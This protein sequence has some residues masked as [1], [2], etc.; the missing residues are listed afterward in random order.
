MF[1]GIIAVIIASIVKM[2]MKN[3]PLRELEWAIV[4]VVP[5]GILGGTIFGKAFIPGMI[6]YHVFFFWEPGM[7]LFGALALGTAAG[8]VWFYKRSK[9]T[10]I[11]VW[12][13]ADCILP[14]V[15]LG[16]AIGRWGN[17]Y[18]HEIMGH[19]VSYQSLGWMADSIRNRLFYFPP[20]LAQ[21]NV[22]S[23]M[24][25]NIQNLAKN[26]PI[27]ASTD[28][29]INAINM[30]S[31]IKV[32]NVEALATALASPIQ[33]REPLFLYE[34]MANCF[35]WFIL[36]FIVANLSRWIQGK[37]KYP[38]DINPSAYP[39]W[40]NNKYK[41]LPESQVSMTTAQ[42]PIKYKKVMIKNANGEEREIK[43]SFYMAWNKAYY[44][45]EA[46]EHQVD[47][48]MEKQEKNIEREREIYEKLDFMKTQEKNSKKRIKTKYQ[49]KFNNL[50]K[51][52]DK[53]A[54][55]KKDYDNELVL[56]TKNYKEQ[57]KELH[58]ELGGFWR[59]F[60]PNPDAR[61]LEEINN[62]N[63]YWILRCGVL[64]GGYVFG[65]MLIR[66]ILET[67]R[68]PEELFVQNYPIAD[69]IVLAIILLMGI[70]IIGIAQF[71][72]PYKWR[73]VGWLYEK[74]Y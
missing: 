12:V 43:M 29:W 57:R 3:I 74:S 6:W 47:L 65:Y 30:S 50:A 71:L 56:M 73:E 44:W 14:N 54:L 60:K 38:W 10:M 18:N 13:Y 66:I 61:K 7:S 17:M 22:S 55:V 63:N 21:V 25:D 67:H 34:S 9:V 23:S 51:G 36:T 52:T 4:I 35:L 59:H 8:F 53:Y 72:S 19:I 48:L 32:S 41:S 11:S 16:Q 24:W 42:K 33:Y 64:T 68:R 5:L 2:K 37:N 49:S 28:A 46:D 39:G 31:D 20:E 26:M 70:A 62:P 69:F 45:Y 40:F 15:L 58:Q 1:I 27:N